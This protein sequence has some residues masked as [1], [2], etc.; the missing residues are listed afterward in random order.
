LR[1]PHQLIRS[2]PMAPLPQD[3]STRLQPPP[4]VP[5]TQTLLPVSL[6]LGPHRPPFSPEKALIQGPTTSTLPLSRTLQ[7]IF[8]AH[9]FALLTPKQNL[10]LRSTQPPHRRRPFHHRYH[11]DTGHQVHHRRVLRFDPQHAEA[12]ASARHVRVE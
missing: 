10:H 6:S 12:S 7:F 3:T 4:L 8:P 11:K 5:A 2:P 1:H 9:Q